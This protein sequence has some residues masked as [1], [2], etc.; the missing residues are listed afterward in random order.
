MLTRA[1]EVKVCDFGLARLVAA[2]PG[3]RGATIPAGLAGTPAYMAPE[4]AR[5]Q[6]AGFQAD[7]FSMGVVFYEALAGTNPFAADNVGDTLDR[8]RNLKPVP[9]AEADPQVPRPL[10]RLV[11]AM[12]EKDPSR[13]SSRAADVLGSLRQIQKSLEISR[14]LPLRGKAAAMAAGAGA[15]N[16]TAGKTQQK[17]TRA[18]E[19]SKRTGQGLH[20]AVLPFTVIGADRDRQV[21]TEGLTET[22]NAQLSKLTVARRLQVATSRETHRLGV[23]NATEARQQFGANVALSSSIQFSADALRVNCTLI[24]TKTD[25][26]LR[27]ETVT[28]AITDSFAV[29]DRVVDAVVRM[30]GIHL[31][32]SE[33]ELIGGH[34]TQEPGAYEFYLQGRGYLQNFDRVE[35]LD[36][37]VIVF[38][39]ALDIDHRYA[40]AYAGLGEAYWRKFEITKAVHW[41]E[42]ARGA[43]E[44]AV[45]ID[46]SLAEPHGCLGMVLNGQGEHEKAASE[47]LLALECDPTN[48]VFYVGL[49][50]AYEKLKRPEDAERT[51]RRAIDARPQYWAAHSALGV[52]LCNA[53]RYAEA[54]QSF[55]R[56]VALAPDNFR[57]Y[58]NLG[59]V[60]FLKDCIPE[61]IASFEKS[62]AIRPNY[63][64]A[65]NLGTLYYFEGEYSLA[66]DAVRQALSLNQSDYKVW[67]HLGSVLREAKAPEESAKAFRRAAELAEQWLRVNPRDSFAQMRL[68]EYT[69]ALGDPEKAMTMVRKVIE[70]SPT[71]PT[72]LLNLAVFFEAKRNDRSEAHFWLAKAIDHGQTWREID[73]S[74]ELAELRKDAAFQELRRR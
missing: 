55:E 39:R 45:A 16:R 57:G 67:G 14:D 7:I 4:V 50:A 73:R 33:R 21:F 27:S 58:R 41:V 32:P 69:A 34:G 8:I 65:S 12:I 19:E 2:T 72:T 23:T 70:S 63:E 68:A 20:L 9:L 51:Y 74:P 66:A 56:V 44:G 54:L 10:S 62:L 15:R 3:D 11:H 18:Q 64:A 38:R 52:Y 47:F 35:N 24:D 71:E 49:A 6:P 59:A 17:Q 13:R 31:R 46:S 22:L 42:L 60:Q 36:S 5:Q 29:Q 28:T 37:A 48:D 61:A 25:K 43:C 30:I 53:G 1:N 40:L 26:V